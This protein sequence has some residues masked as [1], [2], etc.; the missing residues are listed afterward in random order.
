MHRPLTSATK[1]AEAPIGLIGCGRMGRPM[2]SHV[3][4]AGFHG[5][6]N[7]VNPRAAD[8]LPRCRAAATPKELADVCGI[9]LGCVPTTRAFD[10]VLF[11]ADGIASGKTA[12]VY[13]H[14]GT[15]GPGHARAAAKKLGEA[16]IAFVDAP[17]SGGTARA[18]AGSLATLVSGPK[19]AI[20]AARPVL[21]CYSAKITEFGEEPGA[22]QAAKLINNM[23]SAANLAIA[24]EGLLAGVKA[25]LPISNL[26]E[27][28]CQGT[29]RSDALENKIAGHVVTRTFDWGSSLEVIAKDM[30]AWLHMA[31]DV[32]LQS[33][34]SRLVLGTYMS[35]IEMLGPREDMTSITKWLEEI[36]GVAISASN[37]VPAGSSSAALPTSKFEV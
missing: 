30:V 3:L 27:L 5:I 6:A 18:A 14:L 37:D 23:I 9:V 7:D 8:G 22:A 1:S 21:A 17:I 19:A 24:V 11:G 16:G 25:G 33:P 28:L 31:D 36:E 15:T 20:E 29:A 4:A 13:V 35:A 2:M 32:G 10:E 26:V 34:L 12:S